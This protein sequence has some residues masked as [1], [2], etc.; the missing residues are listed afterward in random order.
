MPFKYKIEFPVTSR[1]LKVVSNNTLQRLN[2]LPGERVRRCRFFKKHAGYLYKL[3]IQVTQ[4]GYADQYYFHQTLLQTPC[5]CK[6]QQKIN[7]R[8]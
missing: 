7:T 6:R 3:N 8:I 5:L 4:Q 2:P 1:N